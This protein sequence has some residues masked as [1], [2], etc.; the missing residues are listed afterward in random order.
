LRE[1]SLGF[2][3]IAIKLFR[4]SLKLFSVPTH[5]LGHK[6]RKKRLHVSFLFLKKKSHLVVT[7]YKS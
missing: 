3:D 5:E 2:L 4:G 6:R 1:R 7:C